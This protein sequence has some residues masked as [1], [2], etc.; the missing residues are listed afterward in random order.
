MA[1]AASAATSAPTAAAASAAVAA[2]I[3]PRK[4]RRGSNYFN[5]L[6]PDAM[7][8]IFL[9]LADVRTVAALSNVSRFVVHAFLFP[10]FF[11]WRGV[12]CSQ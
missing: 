4:Q 6:S 1:E 9:F 11:L 12:T 5:A 10:F 3:R 8:I 2:S 7:R